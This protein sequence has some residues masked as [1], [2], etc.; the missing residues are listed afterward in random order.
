[1]AKIASSTFVNCNVS[2]LDRFSNQ[3]DMPSQKKN[4][5]REEKRNWVIFEDKTVISFLILSSSHPI[6]TI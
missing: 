6:L 2:S 4:L 5:L 3:E 1:M